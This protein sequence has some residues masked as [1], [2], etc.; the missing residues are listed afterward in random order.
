[1]P[2]HYKKQKGSWKGIK[3]AMYIYNCKLELYI[4]VD[5]FET[6]MSIDIPN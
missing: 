5:D 3:V 4:Y 6:I 1:M 2:M